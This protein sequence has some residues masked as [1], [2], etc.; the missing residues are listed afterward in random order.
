MAPAEAL[1][2]PDGVLRQQLP[3]VNITVYNRGLGTVENAPKIYFRYCTILA[4]VTRGDASVHY[5]T[6]ETK[7]RINRMYA[8]LPFGRVWI[9]R[10]LHI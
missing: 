1:A 10:T 5:G 9:L 7:T 8:S 2:Q 6:P 4:K 3:P